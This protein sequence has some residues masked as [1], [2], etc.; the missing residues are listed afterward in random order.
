MSRRGVTIVTVMFASAQSMLAQTTTSVVDQVNLCRA[1]K[2]DVQRLKCFDAVIIEAPL[3]NATHEKGP[4]EVAWKLDESK[5]PL[6][7]NSRVVATL[8]AL[9]SDAALRLKCQANATEVALLKPYGYLG[10]DPV[11]VLVGFNNSQ[12]IETR[13]PPGTNGMEAFA[14]SPVQFIRALSDDGRLF[15]RA[16]ASNGNYYDAEFSL[17]KVSMIRDKIA[18]ACKW[19]LP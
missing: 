17:G 15:I 8:P 11:R 16:F 4:A 2:E 14:P 1:I 9:K 5:L 3:T 7:D 19:N 10:T 12:L 13:W 6:D 18:Q